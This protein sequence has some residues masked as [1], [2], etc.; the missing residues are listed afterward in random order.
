LVAI[1]PPTINSINPI[2]ANGTA[3]PKYKAS[4][5]VKKPKYASASEAKPAAM[6]R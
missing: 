6:K 2:P 4:S 5:A 3:A 1:E